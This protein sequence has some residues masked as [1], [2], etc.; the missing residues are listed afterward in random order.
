MAELVGILRGIFSQR[1]VDGKRLFV[2]TM[3]TILLFAY[4]SYYP[5]GG[6]KDLVGAFETVEEMENSPE[7]AAALER[8]SWHVLD[9]S[10]L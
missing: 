3:K 2:N 6:K 1:I 5:C 9:V 4:D 7:Y 8:D 10:T